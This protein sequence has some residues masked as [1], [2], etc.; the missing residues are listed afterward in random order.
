MTESTKLESPQGANKPVGPRSQRGEVRAKLL[1]AARLHFA[2]HDYASVTVR[3]I[4]SDAGA[5][6]AL[7]NYYFGSKAGLFR[8]AMS[9]PADPRQVIMQALEPGLAGA[10]ER[11][12]RAVLLLWEQGAAN[13]SA[14]ALLQ[15]LV[16]TDETLRMFRAWVD[17]NVMTPAA[18]MIGGPSP[19]VRL[20]LATSELVGLLLMRYIVKLEP[21]AS[22]SIDQVAKLAGTAMQRHLDGNYNFTH[23]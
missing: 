17:E 9:L 20:S 18:R 5:D 12:A 22:L 14:K 1:N 15:S 3:M 21:V 4:A 2:T 6:P 19:K 11:V 23:P 7:V 8:E 13:E 10:G 16:S